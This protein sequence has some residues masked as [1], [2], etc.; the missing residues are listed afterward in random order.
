VVTANCDT[1]DED[2]SNR[3]PSTLVIAGVMNGPDSWRAEGM[4]L[5]TGICGLE[6]PGVG[7]SLC[8]GTA[9]TVL[10]IV[11]DG[12]AIAGNGDAPKFVSEIEDQGEATTALVIGGVM[13]GP[14][15]WPAEGVS[16]STGICGLE[17]SGVG[18]WLCAGTATIV[19]AIVTGGLAI[20]D[21]GDAS[22]LSSEKEG[23]REA[24]PASAGSSDRV[25]EL[26]NSTPFAG[27]EAA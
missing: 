27:V 6:T 10:A 5:S 23:Q 14:E 17:A 19:L 20:A 24:T 26:G 15:S 21:N 1:S 11:T 8:A 3:T 2:L 13:N 7:D 16:L 4:S 25:C 22:R 18:D 9:T 12:L